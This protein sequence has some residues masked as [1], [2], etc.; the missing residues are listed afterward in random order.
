VSEA[1]EFIYFSG[2]QLN[3]SYSFS[4]NVLPACRQAGCYFSCVK[5]S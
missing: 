1:S 2:V 4:V 3:F 5:K